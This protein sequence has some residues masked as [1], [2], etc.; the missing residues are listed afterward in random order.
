M[1]RKYKYKLALF[2]V[3]VGRTPFEVGAPFQVGEL[4]RLQIGAL[5]K[6]K[7][8][9]FLKSAHLL[10]EGAQ[11]DSSHI[12]QVQFNPLFRVSALFQ[13]GVGRAICED[14]VLLKLCFLKTKFDQNEHHF[15]TLLSVSIVVS[16]GVRDI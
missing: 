6:F 12:F 7:L 3:R 11:Y 16:V 8:A 14:G 15:Y 13:G 1:N 9:A 2:E 10:K 5:F 4:F